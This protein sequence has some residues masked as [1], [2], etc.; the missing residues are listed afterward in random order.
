MDC[1]GSDTAQMPPAGTQVRVTDT[2]RVSRYN[3]GT[4]VPDVATLGEVDP[5]QSRGT[6][7]G[8]IFVWAG[9]VE[10]TS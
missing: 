8:G 9:Q 7:S 4:A 2:S 5:E 10:R 6:V 3:G 1:L